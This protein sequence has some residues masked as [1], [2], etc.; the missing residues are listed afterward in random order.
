MPRQSNLIPM[1]RQHLP[2]QYIYQSAM[3]YQHPAVYFIPNHVYVPKP[4]Q[5]VPILPKQKADAIVSERVQVKKDL[6][7]STESSPPKT[8]F[9]IKTDFPATKMLSPIRSST[10]YFPL[11]PK[12]PGSPDFLRGLSPMLLAHK[13]EFDDLD[14]DEDLTEKR[15]KLDVD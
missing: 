15:K 13:R 14:D 5:Y 10:S 11:S 6:N 4:I 12:S 7:I 9:Q 1:Q 3:F 2:D 8:D